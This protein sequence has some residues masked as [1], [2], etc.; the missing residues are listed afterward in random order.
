MPLLDAVLTEKLRTAFAT[1][2]GADTWVLR[3]RLCHL[4][5]PLPEKVQLTDAM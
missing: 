4:G 2:G 5:P 1:E 3:T